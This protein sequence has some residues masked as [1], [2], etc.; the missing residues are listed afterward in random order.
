VFVD[1]KVPGDI[2]NT[3]G[4]VVG[5]CSD[6]GNVRF[7]TLSESMPAKAITAAAAVRARKGRKDPRFLTVPFL[8]S[9]D[10]SDLPRFADGAQTLEQHIVRKAQGALA[11]GCDGV[12]ASGE[13]IVVCRRSL[14]P[15]T[16]IVSPGIRPT[17]T[18]TDDHKRHTT[19]GEAIRLG[20][21]YLVVGRPILQASHPHA[22]A[23]RVIDEIT[24]ALAEVETA[25]K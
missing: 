2:D 3:V 5:L 1:L 21:D 22:A 17:G 14:P 11:A 15:G 25:T 4:A 18:S 20:A 16:L 10:Q 13:A 6:L 8:S 19:P 7:L 9:L 12:I 23:A 24:V